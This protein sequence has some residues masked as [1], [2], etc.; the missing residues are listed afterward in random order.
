MLSIAYIPFFQGIFGTT[1]LK[2]YQWIYL[3]SFMPIMFF[4]EELR[5]YMVRK[6]DKRNK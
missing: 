2:P 5:K 3:L 6:M 1:T 4:A